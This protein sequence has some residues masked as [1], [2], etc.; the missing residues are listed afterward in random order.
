M[1]TTPSARLAALVAAAALAL[2]ACSSSTDVPAGS[3]SASALSSV[4]STAP[5]ASGSAVAASPASA[6]AL[7]CAAYFQLDLLNSQYAGGAV[8]NGNMTEQQIKADFKRLL[9]D[10]VTQAKLAVADGTADNKL[11]VNSERMRAMIKALKK[12]QILSDLSAA[13]QAKFAKQSLRVQRSCDRA[14]YPLPADNVT[15]R[16]SAG[17]S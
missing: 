13:N 8:A 3:G 14:G 16:T 2:A 5:A 9:A 6:A 1:L 12:A 7:A 17:L 11:Q 4:G 10:M 15:A